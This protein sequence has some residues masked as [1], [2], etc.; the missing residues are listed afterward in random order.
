MQHRTSIHPFAR[1]RLCKARLLGAASAASLLCV[2]GAHAQTGATE[3]VVVVTAQKREQNVLDVP[4]SIST[5]DAAQLEALRVE[6]VEDYIFS[7]PNATYVDSGAY[8]GQNVTFRGISDFSGGL[9]DVISVQVDDIGFSAINSNVIL[10]TGLLDIERIEVLRG[11]QGTLSGRNALGGSINIITAKP[12]TDGIE[13]SATLDVGRFGTQFAKAVLNVPVS[14]TF[15]VRTSGYLSHSDGMIK[16]VGPAGGS[17]GYDN[18]GGRFAARYQPNDRLTVD[19]AVSYEKR[20]RDY[21]N[22]ITHNFNPSDLDILNPN[23]ADDK[24]PVLESWGGSYPGPVDFF[25]DVGNNGGA[26]S[27]DVNEYTNVENWTASLKA[28]YEFGAHQL[29]LIYGHFDYELDH[30]E[31]YDTT[32]YARWRGDHQVYTQTDAVELRLSSDYEGWINW[33]AGVSYLDETRE[34]FVTDSI[35]IWAIEGGTPRYAAQD[36]GYVPAYMYQGVNDLSSFGAFA[37]AFVDITPRLH[38][39]A[40]V[41]YSRESSDVGQVSIY[42]PTDPNLSLPAL[43]PDDYRANP[44]LEEFS[45]RVALNYDITDT[46]TVYAQFATGYR[47][48]YGN[49]PLAVEA[50]APETV[51]PENLKNYEV[52]FKGRL[53]DNR[54]FITGALFYMDYKDLQIEAPIPAALNPFPFTVFYDTNAG[55]AHTMGFELEAQAQITNEFRLETTVGYTD[56]VID[57]LTLVDAI[58]LVETDYSDLDIPNVRPWTATVTGVYERQIGDVLATF[59]ALYRYQDGAQWQQILPDPNYYLPSFQTLDLSAGVSKGPWDMTV[60]F[61][62][63]LDEKYFTSVG[64]ICCGYRGRLVHTPPRMFGVRLNYAFKED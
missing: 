35:G 48:G 9:F 7:I 39:S 51:D 24:L 20:E 1:V 47:A 21:E 33:V 17:S 45:P 32:E 50:N 41:R 16:N 52:G 28:S 60:Y 23:W 42:D 59:R 29:D 27:K 44:T 19:A 40:G 63:V 6:N 54:L 10:S 25:T 38:L 11:P 14:E 34:S 43:T 22:W 37:N 55:K 49:T 4:I 18:F 3:D 30:A 62:N 2:T 53:F 46:A 31:D 8:Y 57:D 58:T 56:A 64:W 12:S 36:G 61:E 26:V 5:L 15:A 13:G